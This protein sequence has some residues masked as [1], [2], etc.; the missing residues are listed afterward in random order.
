MAAHAGMPPLASNMVDSPMQAWNDS[1]SSP[2]TNQ[3][4]VVIHA[5][6]TPQQVLHDANVTALQNY[7]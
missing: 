4:E 5:M 3:E 7:Q 1:I 6:I 2:E